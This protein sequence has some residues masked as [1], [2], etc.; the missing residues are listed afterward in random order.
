MKSNILFFLSSCLFVLTL[1][2]RLALAHPHHE[3]EGLAALGL[4]HMMYGLIVI[5]VTFVLFGKIS[6]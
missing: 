5:V 6:K 1:F 4:D 3:N 2:Q